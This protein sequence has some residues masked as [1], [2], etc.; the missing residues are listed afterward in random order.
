MKLPSLSYE[1]SASLPA[2]IL[3]ALAES[4]GCIV[5]GM[6]CDA[7]DASLEALSRALGQPVNEPHNLTGGMVCRIEVEPRENRPY[8]STPGHFPGHT[9]C[10]DHRHPPEIVLLL[11]EQAARQGGDSFVARLP[12]I[13]VKLTPDDLFALQEPQFF[14]RYGYLPI[15]S[16]AKGRITIRYNR[17]LLEMFKPSDTPETLI[18]LLDRLDQAIQ[19]ASFEFRLAPGDCLI[20]DNRTTV[21]GRTAFDD[22]GSRLMKRV[23]VEAP[24]AR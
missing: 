21:H 10:S 15:L 14:F 23:R 24:L 6:P 1:P 19:A 9:D 18:H 8:A 12:E 13:L 16:L 17:Q 5:T 11:C 2:Q 7:D 3:A 4:G 22:D 20:L